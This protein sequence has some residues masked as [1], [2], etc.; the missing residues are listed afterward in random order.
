MQ[1]LKSV[2]KLRLGISR[3]TAIRRRVS[4]GRRATISFTC[5]G[6]LLV[7]T[8]HQGQNPELPYQST[9]TKKM[10]ALLVKINQMVFSW[11]R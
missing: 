11:R 7:P 4:I 3:A 8:V 2:F 5:L 9:G 10:A 6:L 1:K